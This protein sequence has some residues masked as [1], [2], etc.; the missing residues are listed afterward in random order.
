MNERF[1]RYHF[2][3]V[4]LA[5]CYSR[6]CRCGTVRKL[7]PLPDAWIYAILLVTV[8]RAK[9]TRRSVCPCTTVCAGCGFQFVGVNTIF[10]VFN[11]SMD[12]SAMIKI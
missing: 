6:V 10:T 8:F 2:A 4:L 9:G 12:K 5:K 3:T 11:G 7:K 1:T